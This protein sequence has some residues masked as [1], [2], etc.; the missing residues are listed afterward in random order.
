[1]FSKAT[2]NFTR[3]IDPD[4]ILI[5]VSRLNDSD[6]LVPMAIIVKRKRL[7]FWQRPKYQPTDF[8]LSDLLVED[9]TLSPVVSET[10]FLGYQGTFTDTLSG[11]LDAK[12]GVV[13]VNLEGQGSSKLQ[14]SFGKLKKQ[15]VDVKQLLQDSRDR[16]VNMQHVLVQQLEKRADVLAVLKEKVLTTSSCSITETQQKRGG[17]GG[18]LGKMVS[19][20]EVCVKDNNTIERDSDVSLEIPRGTV[21]AYSVLELEIKKDGQYELCLQPATLGGFEADSVTASPFLDSFDTLCVVDGLVWREKV[22]ER[23]SLYSL[24]SDLQKLEMC[25][26]DLAELPELT[27]S[28]LSQKLQYTL[29]DRGALSLLE[30]MLEDWCRGKPSAMTGLESDSH[31][32]SVC[33]VLDLL[34]PDP[35]KHTNTPAHLTA[36]HMLVSAIEDLQF[37]G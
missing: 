29:K 31:S 34:R 20:P 37:K 17:C 13:S 9:T 19:M 11:K 35:D 18:V 14:S 28:A 33:S 1:M 21:I 10:D 25:L 3:Q 22:P 8:T 5:P 27:R 7:W 24:Q 15:E 32:G 6:K 16:L 30:H 12:A 4:E 26:R 36:A 2:A 23:E